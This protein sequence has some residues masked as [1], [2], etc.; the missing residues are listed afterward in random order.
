M[1][2]PRL[3]IRI[4][5]HAV[6]LSV[7]GPLATTDHASAL[8]TVCE[9]LPDGAGLVMNLSGVTV[10][11]EAGLRGLRAIASALAGTG[12]PVAF[13]CSDLLM[14]AELEMADLDQLVPLLP[15]DEEALALVDRA[16]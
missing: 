14:R 8:T 13:V 10:I 9:H 5:G 6:N 4:D 7:S 16:A 3:S 15:G 11:T 12:T 1:L 2:A